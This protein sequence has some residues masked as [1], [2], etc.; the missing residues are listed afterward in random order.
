MLHSASLPQRGTFPS[1]ALLGFCHVTQGCGLFTFAAESHSRCVCTN[2][3]YL[4]FPWWTRKMDSIFTLLQIILPRLFFL[5]SLLAFASQIGVMAGNYVW[6]C[7]YIFSFSR[8]G[9]FSEVLVPL[10]LQLC[11]FSALDTFSTFVFR[12]FVWEDLMVLIFTWCWL[13]ILRPN[14]TLVII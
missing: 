10:A 13:K 8:Y 1:M 2:L 14:C 4:F 6:Q 12:L 5:A 3:G 11:Q 9:H 7:L